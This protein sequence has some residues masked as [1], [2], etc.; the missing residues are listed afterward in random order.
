[1]RI[2]KNVKPRRIGRRGA[3]S[4]EFV[5]VCVLIAAAC[6]I[7]IAVMGRAIFRSTDL[8]SKGASGQG[9][10]AATAVSCPEEGYRY[11]AEDDIKESKKFAGEFSDT[12]Q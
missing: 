8:M 9:E 7:G 2:G 6:M 11:Q 12:K 10:L 3:V 4:M 1:M 5:V